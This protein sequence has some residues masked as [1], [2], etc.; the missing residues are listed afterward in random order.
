MQIHLVGSDLPTLP[1]ERVVE[2]LDLLR[3]PGDRVVLGPANDGGY[4]LIGLVARTGDQAVP[5]LF[6]DVRWSTE[7]ARTDTVAAA[8]RC[9]LAVELLGDWYDIDDEKGLQRL[10]AELATEAGARRAP[11]TTRVLHEIFAESSGDRLTS[12][13]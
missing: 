4:Y 5:D 1:A 10:Q 9:G 13:L 2:A 12:D 8:D 3:G 6:T 11:A 7:W